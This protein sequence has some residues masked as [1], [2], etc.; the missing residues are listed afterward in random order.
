MS[1]NRDAGTVDSWL[2]RR[3]GMHFTGVEMDSLSGRIAQALYPQHD[4]RVENFRDNRLSGVQ[5]VVGNVAFVPSPTSPWSIWITGSP[6]TTISSRNP[7]TLWRQAAVLA[8]VTSRF[9]LDKVNT[10]ARK[11]LADLATFSARSGSPTPLSRTGAR[12]SAFGAVTARGG[13][14]ASPGRSSLQS[15]TAVAVRHYVRGPTRS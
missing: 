8:L 11:Y 5:A 1:S 7:W 4:I 13:G 10:A 15:L 3:K 2:M 12:S 6:C 14:L 9:M